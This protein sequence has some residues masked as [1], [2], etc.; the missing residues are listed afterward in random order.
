MSQPPRSFRGATV[1]LTGAASGMGAQM[2]RQLAAEGSQTLVVIDRDAK[3]LNDLVMQ[4]GSAYPSVAVDPRVLDLADQDATQQLCNSLVAE[5]PTIDLLINNA[6]VTV[7]GHFDEVKFD[8]IQW[9]LN[10]NLISPIRMTHSLLPALKASGDSHVINMSSLFGLITPPGQA[11]YVTS[12]FGLRGFSETIRAE[13]EED[14]ITVTTIHP[15]GVRT[16]IAVNART[17]SGV[18]EQAQR[19]VNQTA[20]KM[21]RLDPERAAEIILDSARK[22]RTYVLVGNDAKLSSWIPRI[23]PQRMYKAMQRIDLNK[24]RSERRGKKKQVETTTADR[25][26]DSTGENLEPTDTKV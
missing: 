21:L 18:S 12:K 23:M 1:V 15:G 3:G 24:S 26:L 20:E 6:G 11:A 7:F 5:Y 25:E 19:R 8:D 10:I 17:G 13:L 2:A 9:L 4:L 22:R 16:G 14:G